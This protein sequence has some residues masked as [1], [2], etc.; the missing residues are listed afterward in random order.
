[1]EVN[2]SVLRLRADEKE[3][4]H[5]TGELLRIKKEYQIKECIV[6]EL[7]CGL[8]GNLELFRE[9]N[10]V[11]GVDG[12]ADAASVCQARGLTVIKGDLESALDLP[13]QGADWVLCLDVLEH[14]ANAFGLMIEIRR[15]LREGGKAVLNVPSHFTL[16]GRVK[17]LFGHDLDVHGFFPEHGEW[18]NPHLRFFTHRGIIRL[19]HAAG[20]SLLEDRS[21][22]VHP[23][24]KRGMFEHLGLGRI[25]R[26]LAE[27]YPSMFA[28]GFFLIIE[29]P[30]TDLL[31]AHKETFSAEDTGL[32]SKFLS[33]LRPTRVVLGARR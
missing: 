28:A 31:R 2:Y 4:G 8:G 14:L 22:R 15:I 6:V 13:T 19:V 10:E 7:G 16:S 33:F 29:K 5:I 32:R 21:G 3:R 20:F 30:R 26:F 11:L 24:S 25:K 9:D 18:D 12:L 23:R 17:L 1:M 27:S